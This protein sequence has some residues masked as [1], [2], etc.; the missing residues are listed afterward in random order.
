LRIFSN[1]SADG[2]SPPSIAIADVPPPAAPWQNPSTFALF[3]TP[4]YSAAPI[5]ALNFAPESS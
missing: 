5:G 1:L 4:G 3:A 2:V